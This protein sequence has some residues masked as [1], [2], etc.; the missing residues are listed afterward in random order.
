[1]LVSKVGEVLESMYPLRRELVPL[2]IGPPGIG[3]TQGIYQFAESI[4]V[5]VVTF[6]LSNTVPSELSGIRMPDTEK[7]TL[8][9]FDDARMASLKDGDILFLDEILE[10]PPALWSACLTLIQDRIMASGRKLPDVMIVAAS[11]PLPNPTMISASVRD[12]FIT[13]D[14][15][16]D[17]YSWRLWFSK[18]KGIRPSSKFCSISEEDSNGWNILTPRKMTK[19]WDWAK[20]EIERSGDPEFV[21]ELINEMHGG[22]AAQRYKE[23]IEETPDKK[24]QVLKALEGFDVPD[25]ILDMTF[26]KMLEY[27]MSRDDWED[28]KKVL[29]E[30]TLEE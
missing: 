5:N 1:M 23:M 20:A 18:N 10:A 24:N 12:R 14:V 9:V 13:F 6:I 21:I 7:R 11:N 3:K 15:K 25:D 4:G 19:L 16:W 26:E 8:E 17:E 2:F 30:T 28:I 27:L 22:V 29:E